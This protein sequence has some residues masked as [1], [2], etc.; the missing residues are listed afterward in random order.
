[1]VVSWRVA[2]LGNDAQVA[3]TAAAVGAGL[4]AAGRDIAEDLEVV[5]RVTG[6]LTALATAPATASA[7]GVGVDHPKAFAGDHR[8]AYGGDF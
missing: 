1:M 7:L 5:A 3:K 8:D 2:R 6:A 4:L